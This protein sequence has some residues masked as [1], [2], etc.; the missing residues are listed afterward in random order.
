MYKTNT[1]IIQLLYET[2]EISVGTI[3]VFVQDVVV[4]EVGAPVGQVELGQVAS[5]HH[6]RVFVA[7]LAPVGVAGQFP[8]YRY[9]CN[10]GGSGYSGGYSVLTVGYVLCVSL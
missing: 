10:H 2:N 7:Y 4:V 5:R 3:G 9:S 8:Q 1:R 6:F